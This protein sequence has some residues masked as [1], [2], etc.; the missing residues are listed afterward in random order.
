VFFAQHVFFTHGVDWVAIVLAAIALVSL[1]R[2][3]VGLIPV[4]L[5]SGAAGML[6]TLSA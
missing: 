6:Y 1:V 3:K 4:I 5:V 2:Y